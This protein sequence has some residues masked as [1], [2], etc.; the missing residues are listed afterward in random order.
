MAGFPRQ[1]LSTIALALLC[2]AAAQAQKSSGSLTGKLTDSYASPLDGATITLRNEANGAEVRTTSGKNGAYRFTG[3]AAGEYTLQADSPQLGRGQVDGIIVSAGHEAR[4]RAA[5]QLELPHREPLKLALHDIEPATQVVSTVLPA[6]QLQQLPLT[7]RHWQDFTFDTPAASTSSPAESTTVLRGDNQA[8]AEITVD[9]ASRTLAFGA[10]GRASGSEID[11]GEIGSAFAQQ[12]R[13][14]TVGGPAMSQ[15]AIR[16]V[17]L[18]SGNAQAEA[19]R[20]AAGAISFETRSGENALHGQAFFFDRQNSWGAQ[21]PFTQW[22][23]QTA[24]A[25]ELTTPVFTPIAYTP[26]DHELTFGA[27]AGGRIRRDKLFWFG[28]IDGFVRN[29]PGL[30]TVRHPDEFFAQPS[31]DDAQVLAARLG[32]SSANPVAEGLAAYSQM[33]Q[34]LDSLLGP[35]PR[36]AAQQVGFA[37]IDWHAAERHHFTFEGIGALWNSPGGGL[38][39]LS[40]TYGSH[41]FGTS[42]ATEQWALARWEAFLTPVPSSPRPLSRPS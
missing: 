23:Q 24:P 41:S 12:G 25:T 35:A 17:Q 30:A 29:D 2:A 14:A 36:T 33:L 9:N 1:S 8:P 19:E 4:V 10:A 27:G 18:A 5:I 3:L 31:N 32:L 28:A 40:E 38:A 39:R 26:S 13:G 15:T 16:E 20:A 42:H 21:N 6:E 11:G 37:R 34:T 22:V 7:G